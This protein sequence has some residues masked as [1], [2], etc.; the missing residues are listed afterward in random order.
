MFP[1]N[2]H[3][4]RSEH[5]LAHYKHSKILAIMVVIITFDVTGQPEQ[6]QGTAVADTS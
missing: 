6:I 1:P 5:W 4:N 2:L 3:L